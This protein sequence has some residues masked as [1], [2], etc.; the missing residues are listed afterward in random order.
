MSM[1][2]KISSREY[3]M[4]TR[5]LC[6]SLQNTLSLHGHFI[7]MC[8]CALKNEIFNNSR[9]R[10]GQKIQKELGAE[11]CLRESETSLHTHQHMTGI[12]GPTVKYHSKDSWRLQNF[13]NK[14]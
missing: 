5:H 9:G 4:D 13:F 7:Y 1:L 6:D 10:I 11:K 3:H 2:R 8:R 12:L 14:I